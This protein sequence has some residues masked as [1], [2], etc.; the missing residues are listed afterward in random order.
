MTETDPHSFLRLKGRFT[1]Q[2]SFLLA[3]SLKTIF[4]VGNQGWKEKK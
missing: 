1:D 3:T 4:L 2:D